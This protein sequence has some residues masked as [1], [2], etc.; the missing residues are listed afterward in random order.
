MTH[1][2]RLVSTFCFT[3]S[4]K[5]F[6]V[7]SFLPFL[8]TNNKLSSPTMITLTF[9]PFSVFT[10]AISFSCSFLF[11]LAFKSVKYFYTKVVLS[12]KML[13]R[14]DLVLFME[15]IRLDMVE[16]ELREDILRWSLIWGS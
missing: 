12:Y 1:Y 15:S 5:Y 10:V 8:P 11:L 3:F 4:Y 16:V 13:F 2:S 6:L 9:Q 7:I 14:F